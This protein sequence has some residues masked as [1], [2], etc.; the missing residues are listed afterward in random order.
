[1]GKFAEKAIIKITVYCLP[2]KGKKLPNNKIR[3]TFGLT[4]TRKF[5]RSLAVAGRKRCSP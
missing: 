1:M 2:T 5:G 3:L 4:Q